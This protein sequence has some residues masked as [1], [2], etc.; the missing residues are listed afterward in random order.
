MHT[1]EREWGSKK[2]NNILAIS[3][4]IFAIQ[5]HKTQVNFNYIEIH[6]SQKRFK[7]QKITFNADFLCLST[8]TNLIVLT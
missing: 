7:N 2:R 3:I 8:T 1:H 4:L 6:K 5:T